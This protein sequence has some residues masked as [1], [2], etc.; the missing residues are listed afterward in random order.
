MK[1][2]DLPSTQSLGGVK[3]KTDKGIIGY[4]SSQW[5]YPNGGAGVWLQDGKSTRIYPQLLDKLEEALEWD[6]AE[7]DEIVNCDTER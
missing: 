6:I 4:W 7:E 1:V 2:K 5:R 3:V